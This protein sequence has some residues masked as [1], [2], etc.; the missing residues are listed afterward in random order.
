MWFNYQLLIFLLKNL[1]NPVHDLIGNVIHVCASFWG[2]NA[3]YEGH[4]LE[5]SITQTGDD[6]PSFLFLFNY[7][8]QVFG[9]TGFVFE[10]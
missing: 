10:I 7:F 2:A 5:L 1:L 9:K 8:G 3:V 4:L 6:F